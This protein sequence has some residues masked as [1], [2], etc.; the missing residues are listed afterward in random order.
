MIG[1][2]RERREEWRKIDPEIR[3]TLSDIAFRNGDT[4]SPNM[5]AF[6]QDQSIIDIIEQK[7]GDEDE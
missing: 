5:K 1:G 2:E 4:L 6:A 7:Q 3:T